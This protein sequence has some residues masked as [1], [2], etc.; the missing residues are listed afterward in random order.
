MCGVGDCGVDERERSIKCQPV[1]LE[2]SSSL[3]CVRP[4]DLPSDRGSPKTIQRPRIDTAVWVWWWVLGAREYWLLAPRGRAGSSSPS[5]QKNLH[6]TTTVSPTHRP[7][8]LRVLPH[9]YRYT[10][11]DLKPCRNLYLFARRRIYTSARPPPPPTYPQRRREHI[12]IRP[13][14]S[15]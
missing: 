9:R 4:R 1:Y 5:R 12:I 8:P 14:Y 3:L 13:L 6:A 2:L 15:L 11:A 10:L 7:T